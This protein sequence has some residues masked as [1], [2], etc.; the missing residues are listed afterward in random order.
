MGNLISRR[1][2]CLVGFVTMLAGCTYYEND[3]I[4]VPIPDVPDPTSTLEAKFVT[5]PPNKITS[6]YW[7]SADFLPVTAQNQTTGQVPIEDGLFNMS[8]TFGGLTDFNQG[9]DPDISLRAAYTSDSLYILIH[10]KDTLYNASQSNWFYNGP[11]DLNKSGSTAGWT[12][13]GSDD[14]IVLTFDMGSGK[15]DLWNWSLALS[16]P[17]GFAIDMVDNGT[18]LTTDTG[19]KTYVR[20]ALSDNR[21]GPAYEWDG[22]QQELN[23]IPGGFTILDPGYYLL[24]KRVIL[25]NVDDGDTYFQAECAPCHGIKGDGIGFSNPVYVA[26][27]LPGQFNRLTRQA[28]DNFAS[29]AAQHEGSI[30]Y[31]ATETDRDNLFARLRGFSGIPGYYLQNPNGS[32]SDIK[33]VSNVQLAKIDK[34]NK[35]YSLLL[36]RALNTGNTDDIV[37]DPIQMSYTFNL[38]LGDNDSLNKI[39]AVNQQLTF[40]SKN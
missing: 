37:F 4:Q 3:P 40:K 27:N 1:R 19:N 30:H 11:G 17:L 13:Q 36:V 35:K 18:G 38:F 29:D 15:S 32:N 16:E 8:G 28:L 25:G 7:K 10:W 24:N 20:N 31:P 26:L 9:G 23:R 12:S 33:A 22:V 34:F 5:T 39:G 14:N 2:L 21:G 6:S